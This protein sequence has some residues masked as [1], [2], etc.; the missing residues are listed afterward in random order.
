[1]FLVDFCWEDIGRN[2]LED[3]IESAQEGKRLTMSE[4]FGKKSDR[5]E[6]ERIYQ[7]KNLNS[8]NSITQK[9]KPENQNQTHNVRKEGIA[10][11]NQK[12]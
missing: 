11:I 3:R 5:E 1:M 10:P 9:Q 8:F 2:E 12:R 4:T 6:Q 7:Q